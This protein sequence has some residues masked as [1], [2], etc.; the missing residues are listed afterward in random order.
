VWN[1]IYP[2]MDYNMVNYQM[3]K[4]AFNNNKLYKDVY[5]FNNWKLNCPVWDFSR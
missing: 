3:L 1:S 5:I 4:I 2:P